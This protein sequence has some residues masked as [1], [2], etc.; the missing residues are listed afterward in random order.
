MVD[1]P[2]ATQVCQILVSVRLSYPTL[3]HHT[4][5]SNHI[6]GQ[7]RCQYI[8]SLVIPGI[9]PVS[10]GWGPVRYGINSG[11]FQN[12]GFQPPNS[13]TPNPKLGARTPNFGLGVPA[14]NY[15]L[16]VPELGGWNPQ[17]YL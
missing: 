6:P 1:G 17:L 13:R 4:L 7:V 10:T 11:A 3:P 12:W 15:E 2:L 5:E 14:P 16:L 9:Y 8:F